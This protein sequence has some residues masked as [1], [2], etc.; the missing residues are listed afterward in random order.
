MQYARNAEQG[1]TTWA[2]WRT[3]R[4]HTARIWTGKAFRSTTA[5]TII[6]ATT[7]A[8]ISANAPAAKAGAIFPLALSRFE[9]GSG[10]CC[11][12]QA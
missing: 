11:Q 7:A 12:A 9:R 8:F 6:R 2:V 3:I 1:W 5:G 4:A 10:R